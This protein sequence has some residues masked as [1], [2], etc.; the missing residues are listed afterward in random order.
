MVFCVCEL[1][2]PYR[3]E[4]QR[5]RSYRIVY[6]ISMYV[7]CTYEAFQNNCC[8]FLWLNVKI[9]TLYLLDARYV[10]ASVPDLS[11]ESGACLDDRSNWENS[12]EA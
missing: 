11:L 10:R 5:Y 7:R 4:M 6:I 9:Y 3:T 2:G 1:S 8:S 12:T